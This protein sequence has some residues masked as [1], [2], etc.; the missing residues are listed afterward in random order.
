VAGAQAAAVELGKTVVLKAQV[1]SGGRGKAGGVKFADSAEAAGHAAKELF[2]MTINGFS[3]HSVLV[4]ERLSVKQEFYIALAIDRSARCVRCMMSNAGGMDIELVA[5]TTPA[6]IISFR[7]P[8]F[9]AAPGFEG[10]DLLPA[11][12]GDSG[13]TAGMAAASIG[14]MIRLFYEKDCS[15]LEVNPYILTYDNI[16][17]AADAKIVID[18]NA[19]CKH[20]DMAT[21]RSVEEY[22]KEALTALGAGLSFVALDG[23]V[24]CMVNGAGLAMATMDLI[25]L[26]G[27]SPA[28]FLDV[29]GS[30]NPKKVRDAF[31]ILLTNAKLKVLLVNIFGG[32]T[33][34][35]DIA[36]GIIMAK[37]EFG[38]RLPIVVRL[39]GT[40]EK[41]GRA[42]LL[43]EGIAV[44]SGM[45]EAVRAAVAMQGG[46]P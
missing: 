29:G 1:L 33:R 21:M 4:A 23:T 35:D 14:S 17:F 31:A 16:F 27:A 44:H 37:K 34:C 38:V 30:S 20:P 45:D 13:N 9:S 18:D 25:R 8:P 41:E 7:V 6:K 42:L 15:L 28:N 12:F 36:A 3:V 2:A 19:L 22:G 40:N 24:G 11:V 32:I 26:Y 39:T 10:G 46:T 5:N 43:G